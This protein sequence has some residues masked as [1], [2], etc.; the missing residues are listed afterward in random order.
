M[1]NRLLSLLLI[2]FLSSPMYPMPLDQAT[3]RVG[4]N[5]YDRK[6]YTEAEKRFLDIVKKY[7]DSPMFYQSLFLLGNTYA[8]MGNFKSALQYYKLLLTKSKSV[9]EKQSALLG[10]A[11]SWLQLGVHDK[12]GDFYSFFASEYPE[13]QHAAGALYYAGIARE[14][15]DDTNA[16]IAIIKHH[17]ISM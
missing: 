11:K 2:F 15:G 5:F 7:P 1:K 8:Q 16:A 6:L 9:K 17:C 14:R 3:F 12:A 10:I 4:K 13:S